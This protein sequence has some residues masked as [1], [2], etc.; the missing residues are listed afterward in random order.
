MLEGVS[1]AKVKTD[2]TEEM[3]YEEISVSGKANYMSK[4]KSQGYGSLAL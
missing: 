4:H 3:S 1:R 2:R